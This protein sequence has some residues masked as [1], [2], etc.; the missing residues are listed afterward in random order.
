MARIDKAH[1]AKIARWKALPAPY[2]ITVYSRAQERSIPLGRTR[3]ATPQ[4]ALAAANK[5]EQ[6]HPERGV[7]CVDWTGFYEDRKAA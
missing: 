6:R 2:C 5:A 3:Y 1:E 7:V 4:E